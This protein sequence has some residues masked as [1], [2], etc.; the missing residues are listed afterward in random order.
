M[1]EKSEKYDGLKFTVFQAKLRK[2]GQLNLTPKLYLWIRLHTPI[3]KGALLFLNLWRLGKFQS[4]NL[5]KNIDYMLFLIP[6]YLG[7]RHSSIISKIHYYIGTHHQWHKFL[8]NHNMISLWWFLT[9]KTCNERLR[10]NMKKCLISIVTILD[11]MKQADSSTT[12]R[13]I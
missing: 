6:S 10:N 5:N 1:C 13:C 12:R 9:I 11:H 8:F 4:L 3:I 2:E 7:F